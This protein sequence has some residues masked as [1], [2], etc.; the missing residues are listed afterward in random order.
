V[1]F[2]NLTIQNKLIRKSVIKKIHK[3]FDH[4]QYIMGPEV[5]KLENE[6]KNFSGAKY[7]ITCSNGTD[8]ILM[9]LMAINVKPGDEVI[10]SP[11]SFIA[12]T[13]MILLLGAKPIFA[14]IC[15]KTFNINT[16]D[17]EKKISKKTKAIIPISLF[18]QCAEL[19]EI[20]QLA[21]RY[22]ITVIEDAAQSFGA[23]HYNKFSCNICDISTTSFFPSKPLGGYGDG[24]A[25][26]TNKK[27]IYKKIISL[28]VHGQR[29]KYDHKYVG[30]NGRMDTI[31]AT[32]ISEKLKKFKKEIILRNKKAN[33]YNNYLKEIKD[34]EIPYIEKYNR[35]VYAQYC[36]KAKNRDKLKKFLLKN[37]IPSVIYYPKLISKQ[38]IIKSKHNF[39]KSSK[40]TKNILAL[41]FS[42]YINNKDIKKISKLIRKFYEK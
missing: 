12:A 18:G 15:E 30:I 38:Q 5:K 42:P 27:K 13:E 16:N 34:I 25:I 28:R 7:C 8:A 6:L 26:F 37:N 33:I 17:L 35:S 23:A 9:A 29:K 36:I 2:N 20:N 10:T 11:F 31:Q 3:I 41:P 4:G 21:K 40:I 39:I 32:I 19:N 1:E 24:G 14:D 22:K